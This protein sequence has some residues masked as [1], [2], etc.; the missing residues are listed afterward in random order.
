[1]E[2]TEKQSPISP[3]EIRLF[4]ELNRGTNKLE[5]NK[6]ISEK[7]K[8]ILP[9]LSLPKKTEKYYL[10]L[11]KANYRP[12]GDYQNIT[13]DEF[14]NLR[15]LPARRTSNTK[16]D[17]Y[18]TAKLPFKGSNLHGKW[19]TDSRGIE[20]YVV[21]SYSWYPIYLFKEGRW[22]KTTN[23]YSRATG[24]QI[25]NVNPIEYDDN[26]GTDVVWVTKKEMEALMHNATYEDIMKYKTKRILKNK[27][28]LISKRP[29]F[30]QS[31]G[32]GEGSNIKVRFKITD[33]REEDGKAIVDVTIDDAGAREGNKLIPSNGGY[34][35]GEIPGVTKEKVEN[36]IKNKITHNFKEYFGNFPRFE[37]DT[38][39]FETHPEKHAFKFNFIHSKA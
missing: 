13:S 7:L 24:R 9:F 36:T 39:D 10:E 29:T 15:H 5:S 11:Y 4:K 20:Y 28:E 6:K 33:I 31:W 26:V 27:E 38:Y 30:A 37:G 2:E 23:N 12:E 8:D 32:Y 16:S 34:L 25:S 17:T 18:S 1:M 19:D 14:V 3:V 22:Y 21:M 35:R